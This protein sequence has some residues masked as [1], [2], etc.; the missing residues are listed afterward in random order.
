MYIWPEHF[1]N[2]CPPDEAVPL[3]GPVFRFING[4][5]PAERDFTSHFERNAGK[6]WG[7][8][9][10][11]ARGL[12]VLRTFRDCRLMRKGVPALRKKRLAYADISTEV[13]VVQHTPSNTCEG[14][15][16]WW[17]A[18]P[19]SDVRSLFSTYAEPSEPTHA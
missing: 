6:D 1:P 12:S 9:A 8:D 17:R 7:E 19:P 16:T 15:C 11:K 13:G 3:A 10:C 5:A 4:T 2:A 14:H 18:A